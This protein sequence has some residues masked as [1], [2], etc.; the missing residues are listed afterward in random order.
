MARKT[1]N[2][3]EK[4]DIM[5]NGFLV[6]P[7]KLPDHKC[8]KTSSNKPVYHYMFIKKHETKNENER[9]CLFV[10]NIPLLASVESFKDILRQVCERDNTV[11]H[12]EDLLYHDEFGLNE[13]NLSALTSDL[14]TDPNGDDASERRYT[15]RNTALVKL[16]D[17]PSLDNC[18]RALKNYSRLLRNNKASE[19]LTWQYPAT[20]LST[21]L[22]FYKPLNV[23]YL[24]DDV[25]THLSLFEQREEQAQEEIQRSIVDE[26][27]F[28]L[29]VGKHTK[30][31]N[32]LRR[33]ILNRNP[34]LK[35][36]DKNRV[37]KAA[38]AGSSMIEKNAKQDFY[39]FQ[40]R[41]RKKQEINQLL[42]KFKEDQER[43]KVMKERKKFNPYKNN[44]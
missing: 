40:L 24:K 5:K 43:I 18:L 39:R 28:T 21:F 11:A 19:I 8:L 17:K 34:L 29:V 10:V 35:Y 7:F 9:N 41:E 31:L 44:L 33:K 26:D 1:S 23:D 38:A 32:S 14:L 22:N 30:S 2:G 42:S 36:E 4:V 25:Q 6:I 16:V 12:V 20:S 13:V 3:S 37:K 15:P 27:G